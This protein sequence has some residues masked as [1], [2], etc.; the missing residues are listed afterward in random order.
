MAQRDLTADDSG[1]D[2]TVTYYNEDGG[3]ADLTNF[4]ARFVTVGSPGEPS[5]LTLTETDGIT[6]GGADGTARLV[7]TPAQ[8]ATLATHGRYHLYALE[9]IPPTGNRVPLLEGVLTVRRPLV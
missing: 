1:L 5:R 4:Q 8:V 6:L 2:I 3:E 7:L 9:L